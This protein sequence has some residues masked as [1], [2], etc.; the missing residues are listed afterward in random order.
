MEDMI[1]GNSG[2]ADELE[3]KSEASAPRRF[4]PKD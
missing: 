3:N 2:I 1:Q 4:V